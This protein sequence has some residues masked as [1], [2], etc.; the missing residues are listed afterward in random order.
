M[1]HIP[2]TT[3]GAY[4]IPPLLTRLA[5][6]IL[7]LREIM[8]PAGNSAHDSSFLGTSLWSE[9]RLDPTLGYRFVDDSCSQA[10]GSKG[11]RYRGAVPS[12]TTRVSDI[13]LPC[14]C[15][16]RFTWLVH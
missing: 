4:H 5:M 11:C 10:K 12:P 7:L 15:A 3:C 9:S 16:S 14:T 1:L 2:A 13:G 6:P 8:E